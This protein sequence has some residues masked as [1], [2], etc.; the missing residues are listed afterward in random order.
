[1]DTYSLLELNQFIR[2]VV[3]LNF[4]E[5]LWIR[6]EIAQFNKSRGHYFIDLWQ[7]SEESDEAIAQ[8]S[9]V[10][11][12]K[13]YLELFAKH[14]KILNEV[15]TEGTAVRVLVRVDFHPRYGLKLTITDIDPAWTVGQL[16][17][18]RRETIE[19]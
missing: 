9:A 2:Q 18:K 5:S 6:A 8:S 3:S 16:A 13:T 12:A 4:P 1:M 15:L 7:K 11:W 14:G 19:N 10:I 17:L